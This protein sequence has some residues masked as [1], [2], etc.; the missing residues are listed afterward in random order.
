M[1]K[2]CW[3]HRQIWHTPT[4]SP[5]L[6]QK[7]DKTFPPFETAALKT[8]LYSNCLRH[9]DRKI[10][11]ALQTEFADF[12]IPFDFEDDSAR[13]TFSLLTLAA[14]L[15]PSLLAPISGAFG[16]LSGIQTSSDLESVYSFANTISQKM[17]VLQN[18][19]IDSL[20]LGGTRSE[21]SWENEYSALTEEA[22]IW[23][24]QSRQVTFNFTPANR[25][26]QHWQ[27]SDEILGRL[28]SYALSQKKMDTSAIEASIDEIED[29]KS[30]EKLV[31]NTNKPELQRKRVED[32]STRSLKP[33]S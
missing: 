29:R 31:R 28:L 11:L 14:A 33:A 5:G 26:W 10:A 1:P 16:F 12:S 2:P 21:A 17:N 15:R 27:H 7:V 32:I 13:D 20:V 4:R 19:R 22:Q 24:E 9:P 6:A 8:A 30:F 18:V 3:K 25:V 23:K